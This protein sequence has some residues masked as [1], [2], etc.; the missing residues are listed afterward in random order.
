MFGTRGP[1]LIILVPFIERLIRVDT[2]TVT[3]DIEPQ[4][5]IT[6]DNVTY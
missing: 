4:D 6:K 3:L 1:G 2:R 5:V